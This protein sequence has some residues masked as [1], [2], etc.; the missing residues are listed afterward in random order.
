MFSESVESGDE[1]SHEDNSRLQSLRNRMKRKRTLS[2]PTVESAKG[3]D[4]TKNEPPSFKKA[5]SAQRSKPKGRFNDK[6]RHLLNGM[7][8]EATEAPH[9]SYEPPSTLSTKLEISQIGLTIWTA[10]QKDAFFH[11]IARYG[12]DNLPRLA[13]ATEKSEQEVSDYLQLLKDGLIEK[14]VRNSGGISCQIRDVP[15]TL[16]VSEA[17]REALQSAGDVL[18]WHQK[19]EESKQ[20]QKEHGDF[21]LLDRGVAE[22]IEV[23]LSERNPGDQHSD[24]LEEEA[25]E[26]KLMSSPSKGKKPVKNPLA[27]PAKVHPVPAAKLLNLPMFITLS[28]RVFMN[29]SDP[30]WNYRTYDNEPVSTRDDQPKM[31]EDGPSIFHS[32]FS[33][34]H[35]I[36]VSITRRLIHV[37]LFQ[38]T[39]RLRATDSLTRKQRHTPSVKRRDVLSTMHIVGMKE[40]AIDYWA[41]LPARHKANWVFD[42]VAGK[43]KKLPVTGAWAEEWLSRPLTRENNEDEVSKPEFVGGNGLGADEEVGNKN[44]E[45][46]EGAGEETSSSSDVEVDSNLEDMDL[47]TISSSDKPGDDQAQEEA[48]DH[49]LDLRD[50]EESRKHEKQLWYLLRKTPPDSLNLNPSNAPIEAPN[51]VLLREYDGPQEQW[52]DWTDPQAEWEGTV[53]ESGVASSSDEDETSGSGSISEEDEDEDE[54]QTEEEM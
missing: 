16:Q 41:K 31:I 50:M 48:E 15:A 45:E 5:R 22:E 11:A 18:A 42:E 44:D 51:R 54:E 4:G 27:E 47:E 30:E 7:I 28:E 12:R 8:L 36:V 35:R 26:S 53:V 20:E 19:F 40:D 3:R 1:A 49:Y 32:A 21:W 9:M 29:S 23:Q 37:S 46:A 14:I 24:E 17:C 38:A 25:N 52:R 6:Y 10:E 43:S 39:S 13:S 2:D 33:D 34:F